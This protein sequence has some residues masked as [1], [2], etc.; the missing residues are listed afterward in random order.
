VTSAPAAAVAAAAAASAASSA[1]ASAAAAVLTSCIIEAA[2]QVLVDWR[3]IIQVAIPLVAP[4]L[5]CKQPVPSWQAAT[6]LTF[7]EDEAVA[8]QRAVVVLSTC[9]YRAKGRKRNLI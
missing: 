5:S 9:L 4:R 7:I 8:Q 6:H 2:R 1:A 3:S